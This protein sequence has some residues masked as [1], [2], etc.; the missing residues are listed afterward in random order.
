MILAPRPDH[1]DAMHQ[2]WD[3]SLDRFAKF[4]ETKHRLDRRIS[5]RLR[6][7]NS[8]RTT[9]SREEATQW[10]RPISKSSG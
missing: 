5:E 1:V 10:R 7:P 4:I 8:V 6:P 2:F 9:R 3:V